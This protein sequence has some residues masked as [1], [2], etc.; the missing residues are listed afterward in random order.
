MSLEEVCHD[1]NGVWTTSAACLSDS[2]F[3]VSDDQNNVIVVSQDQGA[4]NDEEKCKLSTVGLFHCGQQINRLYVAQTVHEQEGSWVEAE[5]EYDPL[6]RCFWVSAEGG[7]GEILSLKSEAAFARLAL[8]EDAMD[9]IIAPLAGLKRKDWR[10]FRSDRRTNASRG[11]IDGDLVEQFLELPRDDQRKV[12]NYV[13]RSTISSFTTVDD[14]FY[15][16]E[17]LQRLH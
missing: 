15:E 11:F 4:T 13:S 8:I 5:C 6:K 16:I 3:I 2:M 12:F 1:P 14:L 7:I 17:D 10:D 9:K